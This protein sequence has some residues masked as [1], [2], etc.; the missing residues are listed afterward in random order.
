MKL[1]HKLTAGAILAALLIWVVG[2][3]AVTVSRRALEDSIEHSSKMLATNLMDE[4]DRAIHAAIDDWLIY[5]ASP[6]VQRTLKASNQEFEKLQDVQ[7]YID[8]QEEHW[9][10]EPKETVTPFMKGLVASELS[11]AIRIR[12][13]AFERDEG[14]GAYGEVFLT[15]RYG[16][17]AAQTG[18]TTDYRQDDEQWWVRAREDGVYVADVQYDESAAV[19]STDICVR[20]DD[21]NGDFLGVIKAVFDIQGIFTVLRSRTSGTPFRAGERPPPNLILL[22]AEGKVI[23]SPHGSSVGL[24]DGSA[25]LQPHDHFHPG[26]VHRGHFHRHD[27]KLGE[28][29]GWRAVSQGHDEFKSLGWVLIVEHRAEDVLAPVAALRWNILMISAGV[30]VA[31]LVLGLWFSIS[32]S[33]RI[34]RLR[35][36]ALRVGRGE[37]NTP[38]ADK[39]A[40][41]IGEFSR[42]FDRMTQQLSETLVS[43]TLLEDEVAD[44]TRAE[45]RFRVLFESSRDAIMTLAPPS[46]R[47]T[48]GNP[49]TVSMFGAKDEAEFTSLGPWEVSPEYQPDG[50][51]SDEKAKEM[52]ETA[53]REGSNFFEWTH[54]R[55]DGEDFPATVLLARMES[56][57]QAMLQATVR[58]ITARKRAE[59]AVGRER[60]RAE[61]YLNIAE[62]ML[63][64]ID[65]DEKITLINKRGCEILGYAEGELIGENWF[66]TLVPRRARD[67]VRG[68]FRKLMD[69]RIASVEYYENPLLRKDGEERII[70]FHNTVVRDGRGRIT[71]TLLSAEDITDRKRAEEALAEKAD[72][73]QRSNAELQEFAYVASHDLQEPLRM[74]SSYVQLLEKRYADALDDDAHEFIG[75]AVDGAKRMQA[76]INDLLRYSRVG[77]K[78]KPFAPTDCEAVLEDVLSNLEVVVTESGARVTHDPLPQVM[79]DEAQL[80]RLLQNLIGN[81]VKY[82]GEAPPNVH[83]SAEQTG[84]G[85]QFAVRDNGIG[86]EPQYHERIFAVFQRLHARGEY[87]GTGIGLAVARKIVERHGGRIWIES[88]PGTGSTFYFTIPQREVRTDDESSDHPADEVYANAGQAGGG[89]SG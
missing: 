21:D 31:G 12:L 24:L 13:D 65:V 37:L 71:R 17:N 70:S 43:K 8:R 54:K 48:S 35:N 47:F 63:A 51:P 40:D 82:R 83:V 88:E 53:M 50:R 81:A 49:A 45:E 79:A 20:V 28:M 77:T 57:G 72:A 3:Y 1:A 89:P 87:E 4:V 11:E 62:V 60:D 85:W 36:T 69:G 38:L 7:A 59:E 18:K 25:F 68:V 30:T 66:D 2:L 15:N 61:Q 9:R 86:I 67:E 58:D 73:L 74:V 42:C 23:F 26:R 27:E 32:M 16:A 78:G 56:G 41:E 46:W 84:G 55:L 10:A 19:Y 34:T 22:T 52:I 76:L 80:G 6:L 75:Y 33:R 64:T 39:T 5:S 14:Y 44:R 29:I